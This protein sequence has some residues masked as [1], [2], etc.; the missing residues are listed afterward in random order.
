MMNAPSTHPYG[1]YLSNF[2]SLRQRATNISEIAQA[3]LQQTD[4]RYYDQMKALVLRPWRFV[5]EFGLTAV[6]PN[7]RW[8]VD[9]NKAKTGNVLFDLMYLVHIALLHPSL[10]YSVPVYI[11]NILID[12]NFIT[13]V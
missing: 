9:R 2:R 1:S 10:F 6:D 8:P 7:L 5:K 4:E 11:V 13:Y 3:A 12:Y